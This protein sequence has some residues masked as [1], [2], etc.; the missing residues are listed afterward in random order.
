MTASGYWAQADDEKFPLA[1]GHQI[2]PFADGVR[3]GLLQVTHALD[4]LGS[5]VGLPSCRLV[6]TAEDIVSPT[7]SFSRFVKTAEALL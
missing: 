7:S 4:N 6:S 2:R 1:K 5:D 3:P